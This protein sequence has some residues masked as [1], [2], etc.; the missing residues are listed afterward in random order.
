MQAYH[1]RIE[2]LN[3]ITSEFVDRFYAHIST[4]FG[5]MVRGFFDCFF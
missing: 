1:S 4:I 2:M 3:K 5:N